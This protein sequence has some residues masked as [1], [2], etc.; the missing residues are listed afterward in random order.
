M[1]NLYNI[2]MD[3]K[4]V[5][6]L[7]NKKLSEI[8]SMAKEEAYEHISVFYEK[9]NQDLMELDVE[10]N[11]LIEDISTNVESFIEN[12]DLIINSFKGIEEH[13]YLCVE[14]SKGYYDN[15]YNE[16]MKIISVYG[17]MMRKT[18]KTK[19]EF[20]LITFRNL[21]MLQSHGNI[22]KTFC[23]EFSDEINEVYVSNIEKLRGLCQ[24]ILEYIGIKEE[25]EDNSK[26]ENERLENAVNEMVKK[27]QFD[28]RK[29]ESFDYKEM[30][31]LAEDKGFE[32]KWSKGSHKIYEH[33]NTHK[34]LVIPT[35]TLG[36]GLSRVILKQIDSNSN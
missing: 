11:K 19:R 5:T 23:N 27:S 13:F 14:K 12:P 24:G 21:N 17:K 8:E 32:Y 4:G 34:G 33:K 36:L 1:G 26:I 18:A 20:E 22:V 9:T 31:K 16:R 30:S 35:H 28:I 7:D 15:L 25:E 29:S 6:M 10:I 2:Q 3:I